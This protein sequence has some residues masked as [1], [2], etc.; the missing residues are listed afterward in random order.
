MLSV[1]FPRFVGRTPGSSDIRHVSVNLTK[2]YEKSDLQLDLF[3]D[4]VKKNDI[5]YVMDTIRDKFGS[6]AILRA[7]SYTDSGITVDRSKK[8]GGHYA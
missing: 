5:G 8:I 2:L 1:C 7:S 6:T 4:K 3:D